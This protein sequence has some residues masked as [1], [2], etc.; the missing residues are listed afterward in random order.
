[1][2]WSAVD[3]FLWNPEGVPLLKEERES[4]EGETMSGLT[5]EEADIWMWHE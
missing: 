4:N 5:G 3:G 1:M 2:T